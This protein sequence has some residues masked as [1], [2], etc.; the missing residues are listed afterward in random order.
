MA[1]AGSGWSDGM[2][3]RCDPQ[4]V[5]LGVHSG[6]A[7]GCEGTTGMWNAACG[8]CDASVQST[9]VSHVSFCLPSNL[10]GS[11]VPSSA[12]SPSL[13]LPSLPP[14]PDRTKRSRAPAHEKGMSVIHTWLVTLHCPVCCLT[15]YSCARGLDPSRLPCR[16]S[17]HFPPPTHSIPHL[18]NGLTTRNHIP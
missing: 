8:A 13:P 10:G 17:L 1:M 12:F 7:C 18:H 4:F 14:P 15:H 2:R 3:G 9:N 6:G 16:R 11:L 5:V